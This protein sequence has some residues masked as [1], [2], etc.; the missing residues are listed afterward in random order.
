MI[1]CGRFNG[2]VFYDI[3]VYMCRL[4]AGMV[5]KVLGVSWFNV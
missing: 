3:G 4:R 5:F 2:Q 1:F